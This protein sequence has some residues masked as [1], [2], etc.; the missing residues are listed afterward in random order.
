M[1]RGVDQENAGWSIIMWLKW[2]HM[3]KSILTIIK[4]VETTI[5]T[6]INKLKWAIRIYF[7]FF[8]YLY[9][10]ANPCSAKINIAYKGFTEVYSTSSQELECI[11]YIFLKIVRL[12]VSF[13]MINFFLISQND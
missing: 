2:I 10:Q 7:Q 1:I 6:L 4:A 3:W 5:Y 8:F 9:V 13:L 11:D 12:Q